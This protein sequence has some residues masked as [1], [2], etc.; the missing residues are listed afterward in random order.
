MIPKDGKITLIDNNNDN[1][2]D[3]FFIS[4]YITVV[5]QNISENT[6]TV[7]NMISGTQNLILDEKEKTID[8]YK[9]DEKI[10][11]SQIKTGD[12]IKAAISRDKEYIKLMISSNKVSG[13]IKQIDEKHCV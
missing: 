2:I 7:Y 8:M 1:S 5:V 9:G 6:K 4:D 13:I 12:V 3:A 11:F 10:Q